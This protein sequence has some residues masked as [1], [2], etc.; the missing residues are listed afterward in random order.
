MSQSGEAKKLSP[1]EYFRCPFPH[2][3]PRNEQ[4][5]FKSFESHFSTFRNRDDHFSVLR[6]HEELAWQLRRE[7]SEKRNL[8][9]TDLQRISLHAW[10]EAVRKQT[11][12]SMQVIMRK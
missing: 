7:E 4:A 8:S 12:K 3:H 6:L 9:E 1:N 10:L 2:I 5:F 11:G